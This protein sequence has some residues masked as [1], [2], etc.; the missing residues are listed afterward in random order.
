MPATIW[1]PPP[2]R[3]GREAATERRFDRQLSAVPFPPAIAATAAA[4]IGVNQIRARLTDQQAAVTSIPALLSLS[5]A[6]QGR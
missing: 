3:C 6:A 4:L 1:P 2:R 5:R